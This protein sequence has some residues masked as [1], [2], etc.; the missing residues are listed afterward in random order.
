MSPVRAG[1]HPPVSSSPRG[2]DAPRR[3]GR[4]RAHGARASQHNPALRA[5]LRRLAAAARLSAVGPA[6]RRRDPARAA[7][8]HAPRL[9]RAGS[10]QQTTVRGRSS[11]DGQ[12]SGSPRPR[13]VARRPRQH[14]TAHSLASVTSRP[15]H[16]GP[17]GH[18]RVCRATPIANVLP[19]PARPSWA[20]SHGGR[21]PPR[22]SRP[23]ASQYEPGS[24]RSAVRHRHL[25]VYSRL[26]PIAGRQNPPA[27]LYIALRRCTGPPL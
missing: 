17:L 7:C 19:A 3:R 13:A 15:H 16:H 20:S 22:P 21:P 12:A 2:G 26:Q 14:V 24:G 4:G 1:L 11:G 6:G 9:P 27:M 5:S 18:R 8:N 10:L 25:A 23:A